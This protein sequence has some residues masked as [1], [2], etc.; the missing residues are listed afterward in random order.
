MT[1]K[2]SYSDKIHTNDAASMA[3]KYESLFAKIKE[4][5]EIVE[6]SKN[7][8]AI[9]TIDTKID[10]ILE[11]SAG[12]NVTISKSLDE[13]LGKT[14]TSEKSDF[15]KEIVKKIQN[16]NFDSKLSSVY[17]DSSKDKYVKELI[18]QVE[19]IRQSKS[20]KSTIVNEDIKLTFENSSGD[21][22]SKVQ[23]HF[24]I[25]E[26]KLSNKSSVS[27]LEKD[28]EN[29]A[30]VVAKEIDEATHELT[31]LSKQLKVINENK[32]GRSGD[33]LIALRS[34]NEKKQNNAKQKIVAAGNTSTAVLSSGVKIS[35]GAKQKFNNAANVT[36][37]TQQTAAAPKMEETVGVFKKIQQSARGVGDVFD[38]IEEAG[39][40]VTNAL[41]SA[42]GNLGQNVGPMGEAFGKMTMMFRHGLGPLALF[43]A[44]VGVAAIAIKGYH[45]K[46]DISRSMGDTSGGMVEQLRGMHLNTLMP[47]EELKKLSDSIEG[48]FGVSLS[49]NQKEFQNVATKQRLTERVMGKEYA[50]MQMA[51]V[52]EMKGALT[53]DSTS[54]QMSELQN[55]TSALAKTMGVSNKYALD[56]IKAI[57]A[58]TKE[59]AK[60]MDKNS[61]AAVEKQFQQM[62]A[63]FKAMGMDESQIEFM[64]ESTKEAFTEDGSAK[65]LQSA[66]QISN[67][68]PA[69]MEKWAKTMGAGSSKDVLNTM[70]KLSQA[71]GDMNK[72]VMLMQQEDKNLS[73]EE[74]TRRLTASVAAATQAR[75]S[76]FDKV[77]KSG[78]VNKASMI[79]ALGQVNRSAGETG[80]KE[81]ATDKYEQGSTT[82]KALQENSKYND[83]LNAILMSMGAK[84]KDSKNQALDKLIANSTDS[85]KA[86]MEKKIQEF[87][88][89]SAEE[90]EKMKQEGDPEYENIR[91]KFKEEAYK[92]TM[93]EK[94]NNA[95]TTGKG[96]DLGLGDLAEAKKIKG[97]ANFHTDADALAS[98]TTELTG[99]ALAQ[100]SI[101]AQNTLEQ[102]MMKAVDIAMPALSKA[103]DWLSN[104]ITLLIPILAAMTAAFI[105][106]K[107][108]QI[109]K[110]GF[111]MFGKAKNF[112]GRGGGLGGAVTTATG[113]GSTLGGAVTTASGGTGVMGK[114]KSIASG[115]TSTI[116]RVVSGTTEMAKGGFN[117]IKS[118]DMGSATKSLG[119]FVETAKTGVGSLGTTVTTTLKSSM[120]NLGG[121]VRTAG[122]TMSGGLMGGLSSIGSAVTKAGS[123]LLGGLGG[124]ASGLLKFAG[125]IGL[126][127]T[128]FQSVT[129]AVEGWGKATE[130]F[131][132]ESVTFSQ[133]YA[134]A[135]GGAIESLSFGL[136]DGAKTA[137]M[138]HGVF[139]DAW[140]GMKDAWDNV[141]AFIS[142]RW[143]TFKD[144]FAPVIEAG[145]RVVDDIKNIFVSPFKA[146]WS[147]FTGDI[148]GFMSNIENM[149]TGYANLFTSIP[150]LWSE[151]LNAVWLW[152]SDLGNVIATKFSDMMIDLKNWWDSFDFYNEIVTPI[153]NKLAEG[154]NSLAKWWSD[155]KFYDNIIEPIGKTIIDGLTGMVKWIKDKAL[156]FF[157][158]DT[159][160]KKKQE[161][162]AKED[163]QK[164]GKLGDA[165]FKQMTESGMAEDKW[166]VGS[167]DTVDSKKLG[168]LSN[169]QLE[170]LTKLDDLSQE[171]KK[172]IED[173]LKARKAGTK[174]Q[175]KVTDA[176]GK[177]VK[178]K[179][180]SMDALVTSGAI[181]DSAEKN[182]DGTAK[183]SVKDLAAF[184]KMNKEE[185]ATFLSEN[186]GS[187]DKDSTTKL[188]G[189]RD[190]AKSADQIA[191]L[192]RAEEIKKQPAPVASEETKKKA[193]D[194]ANTVINGVEATKS[195]V[196][197]VLPEQAKSAFGI[198][199]DDSLTRARKVNEV[200]KSALE[201]A[202][203]NTGAGTSKDVLDALS[204]LQMAGG[205]INKA[206]QIMMTTNPGMTQEQA[207]DKLRKSIDASKKAEE[208]AI[209]IAN[210]SNDTEALQQLTDTGGGFISSALSSIGFGSIEEGPKDT[211]GLLKS[212]LGAIVAFLAK[213]GAI[214][215]G[216]VKA[217]KESIEAGKKAYDESRA[218]GKGVIESVGTGVGVAGKTFAG[219][220]GTMNEAQSKAYADSVAR[221]ESGGKISAENQFGYIGKYQ[222]GAEALADAGM[223][224]KNKL[225][226]A[227][228]ASKAL[229]K[230]HWYKGGGQKAFLADN[231]NWKIEG[232]KDRYMKDEA[233]QDKV[234]ADYTNKNFATAKKTGLITADDDAATQAGKLKAAHLLGVAGAKNMD[235][236]DANGTSGRKYFDQA[237]SEVAAVGN[238]SSSPVTGSPQGPAKAVTM[239]K[240][241]ATPTQ[242]ASVGGMNMY[243]QTQAAIDKGIKYGFGNKDLKNGSIDCSGWVAC[244]NQAM[245]D[246]V[247][248]EMGNPVYG[249][250]AKKL[251]NGPAAD[252]I[253]NVTDA[254]GGKSIE[255]AEEIKKNLKP[256]MIIGE[257]N[258]EKG[259]D[260]GRYKGID[261][262][263]QVVQDPKTG[264]MMISESQGG[265]GVTMRTAEEYF[266]AKEKKGTK[267][268]AVDPTLL[269]KGNAV[270]QTTQ[271]NKTKPSAATASAQAPNSDMKVAVEK[272][273]TTNIPKPPEVK[274]PMTVEERTEAAMK[275]QSDDVNNFMA[276]LSDRGIKPIQ[277]NVAVNDGLNNGVT[278]KNPNITNAVF[279]PTSNKKQTPASPIGDLNN[280]VGVLNSNSSVM[281][282]NTDGI[283]ITKPINPII[284]QSTVT[285]N[286]GGITIA[287]TKSPQAPNA[288]IT[289]ATNG[290]STGSTT[291]TAYAGKPEQEK[292]WN[293]LSKED[294]SWLTAGGATPDLTDPYI[295]ARLPSVGKSPQ[296]KTAPITD[297]STTSP[298][299]PN[300]AITTATNGAAQKES[301][302]KIKLPA[303][304]T[305][306]QNA[307]DVK[308]AK[309]Y[310]GASE[311]EKAQIRTVTG[312]TDKQLN[313]INQSSSKPPVKN[314]ATD[315]T[316]AVTN[317]P[318]DISTGI[319]NPVVE[320]LKKSEPEKFDFNKKLKTEDIKI[321]EDIKQTFSPEKIEKIKSI[322]TLPPDEIRE[323]L[324]GLSETRNTTMRE[325]SDALKKI[326]EIEELGDTQAGGLTKEQIA[327]ISSLKEKSKKLGDKDYELLQEEKLTREAQAVGG[328][329]R[330]DLYTQSLNVPQTNSSNTKEKLNTALNAVKPTETIT[331]TKPGEKQNISDAMST[332]VA[333]Q[334]QENVALQGKKVESQKNV[335]GEFV[336]VSNV[337][338]T[339]KTTKNP[340]Q[341]KS[342]LDAVTG[343]VVNSNGTTQVKDV[344]EIKSGIS[345]ALSNPTPIVPITPI[346][347]LEKVT[348]SIDTTKFKTPPI[349]ENFSNSVLTKPT[350]PNLY[351]GVKDVSNMGSIGAGGL[352]TDLVKGSTPQSSVMNNVPNIFS[353]VEKAPLAP[354]PQAK[355]PTTNSTGSVFDR[356]VSAVSPAMGMIQ[357]TGT[358]IGNAFNA[359]TPRAAGATIPGTS[360]AIPSPAINIPS[361]YSS[362]STVNNIST[363]NQKPQTKKTVEETASKT[364]VL[365]SQ[366]LSENIK[367]SQYLGITSKESVNQTAQSRK[368]YK[369]SLDMNN[370]SRTQ[371]ITAKKDSLFI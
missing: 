234:F 140:D 126:A 256:G 144:I 158:D 38:K 117:A 313:E 115:T 275:K 65:A 118:F 52:N 56:Q 304:L 359:F 264:Q 138:V 152:I 252:I 325:K 112:F 97:R 12:N 364:E 49:K 181:G 259:W 301:N 211:N 180:T 111:E 143:E 41:Q 300:A 130:Y 23:N 137:Q 119:T 339:S 221:T 171:S 196:A 60:S 267:L 193:N 162:T 343:T 268:T 131:G 94:I 210:A 279:V 320:G 3:K 129:G 40:N 317:K 212:I 231:A 188:R 133:K 330:S 66:M 55:S 349:L 261:H 257:D 134:S 86:I 202:A 185:L 21:F 16:E 33:E 34:E 136:L 245:M 101:K 43:G 161:Q 107:G 201:A 368:D 357:Q 262:V 297:A 219:K 303:E 169:A 121:F 287:S 72:A 308:A 59:I 89:K 160:E 87:S 42:G 32:A 233:L 61:K 322:A 277:T 338:D 103:L 288:A 199:T 302:T 186:G 348:G 284:P 274:K 173:E 361:G 367:Q 246:S 10:E 104:N 37:T 91:S 36:T 76:T 272:A 363:N 24:E 215:S 31:E 229:G 147:L 85:D 248:D 80:N 110:G 82:A 57:H 305:T 337:V 205:D 84:D 74:A 27:E 64:R 153:L 148:T 14:K 329:T 209:K 292:V 189:L 294:K 266:A 35:S 358:N 347:A 316:T 295:M 159:E 139:G 332:G 250:E 176:T 93:G 225:D 228:A 315:V 224:D 63:G 18:D 324:K 154:W 81:G 283:T 30:D 290:A 113:S 19:K 213:G 350:V 51:A 282:P 293:T 296:G 90:L 9:S 48:N 289:T 309:E 239:T 218:S 45:E 310:A 223:V 235:K 341:V 100:A 333:K 96:S 360:G 258:G 88:G 106:Y 344:K 208:E 17:G 15:I 69:S 8:N 281:K 319:K 346:N 204:K 77:S 135:I 269:A 356:V 194:F 191:Q 50:E 13:L 273:T 263:T 366:I 167:T 232:G 75:N 312:L 124:A 353:S 298:Q 26:G 178:T 327:E 243:A 352:I 203:Q 362:S 355:T 123:G 157:G 46:L 265:K 318:I 244:I 54:G 236:K 7:K 331:G 230:D 47:P 102:S 323:K 141:S 105:A 251:F 78:D 220:I 99:D 369:A 58:N 342:K 151:A 179:V 120:A 62:E 226:E 227:K 175:E 20:D 299:A 260:K 334:V 291:P 280:A 163:I 217:G 345:N 276:S 237:Y 311:N 270:S 253:K 116:G 207:M 351:T 190:N 149:F 335:G 336:K 240:A 197:S 2:N 222:T 241:V 128:A 44:A 122:S 5:A 4:L 29:L 238:G 365:L 164:G 68:D 254:T 95:V 146:I 174:V 370:V 247:V 28:V 170:S 142:K 307:A 200:N 192:N 22:Q 39:S 195:N 70:S 183:K 286:N 125:P 150:Q 98:T 109:V 206:S 306:T 198:K 156:S 132:T 1:S 11:Y 249:K 127:V 108:A 92:A 354:L 83:S 114:I 214:V 255:G 6:L 177:Q 271:A 182:S 67:M 340:E 242:V 321:T 285:Q 314:L 187:L 71:G 278:S 53:S 371:E 168:I 326:D 73:T 172:S 165:L 79:Q 184:Q 216:T 166:G 328:K 25:K 145:K 155:Y